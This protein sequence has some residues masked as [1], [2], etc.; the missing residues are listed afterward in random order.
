[1]PLVERLADRELLRSGAFVGGEWVTAD[2]AGGDGRVFAVR[3]PATGDALTELP[4]MGAAQTRQAIEAARQALPAWRAMSAADRSRILR[5]WADGIRDNADDIAKILTAEQ[6]K[7]VDEAKGEVVY[8][9]GFLD[10]FAEE[11]RRTYGDIIPSNSQDTRILVIKQPVGVTAGITPWNLPAAMITR[12]A[13]PALA[14]GNTM[15]LK[16]A[17]QTPLTALALGLLAER[18]GLPKGVLNIVTADGPDAPA[19][20]Q[21]LTGNPAV[22]KISF[23]GSTE[24]GKLLMGQAAKRVQ[25]VSLE[26]GGNSPFIIFDDAD[27][28]Q[29]VAGIVSAKFRNAGQICTAANRILVQRG[30]FEEFSELLRRRAESVEVGHGF[31]RGVEMGPLIDAQGLAKVERHVA[32]LIDHGAKVLTGGHPHDLGGT[33]YQPTVITGITPETMAWSEETFGP[34]ASLT[35]FDDENDAITQANDTEYGLVSYIYT[36][37]V[38][39]VFRVSEALEAGMVAVNTGRVS[40]EQAPFGGIKESGIG[41]EGSKYGIDDWLNLKYINLAGLSRTEG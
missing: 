26:L 17:E 28:K 36:H 1:V 16:P 6:G 32:D 21:E 8:S 27:L 33:F 23:T 4:A 25:K 5:R 24:V 30:V 29:A 22:G 41:R 9:A 20:G 37:D 12:K 40:G 14:A 31:D 18:A 2:G 35:V 11:G 13:A 39:R 3:D 7:P 10:W 34:V 15:V 19:I 38:G